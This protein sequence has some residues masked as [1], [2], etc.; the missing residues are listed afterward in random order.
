MNRF[1][2]AIQQSKVDLVPK[3]V[4]GVGTGRVGPRRA[5]GVGRQMRELNRWA[6]VRAVGAVALAFMAA[7][8]RI[9]ESPPGIEHGQASSR[10]ATGHFMAFDSVTSAITSDNAHGHSSTIPIAEGDWV[11]FWGKYTASLDR[12]EPLQRTDTYTQ[13]EDPSLHPGE[14]VCGLAGISP[15]A[16]R[17]DATH[18][19]EIT[20]PMRKG[21]SGVFALGPQDMGQGYYEPLPG[22]GCTSLPG[23]PA[24]TAFRQVATAVDQGGVTHELCQLY[25]V[26]TQE[27]STAGNNLLLESTWNN[28]DIS[29]AFIRINWKD[30][31]VYDATTDSVVFDWTKLDAEFHQASKRGKTIFLALLAGDGIPAWIFDDFTDPINS[32]PVDAKLVVP[33]TLRDTV[34]G[35]AGAGVIRKNASPADAHYI[36]LLKNLVHE[37]VDHLRN[38]ARFFQALGSLKVTGANFTTAEMK[39]QKDCT[40]DGTCLDC[41]CNTQ[42]WQQDPLGDFLDVL[43]VDPMTGAAINNGEATRGGG[44][45]EEKLYDFAN[46]IEN[47]IYAETQGTKSLIFML[48]QAGF[49]RVRVAGD[50]WRESTQSGGPV[51]NDGTYSG[52]IQT[53]RLLQYGRQGLFLTPLRSGG[54]NASVGKLFVPQHAGLQILPQDRGLAGCSQQTTPLLAPN[55]KYQAP[56]PTSDSDSGPGCPN[57]WAVDAGYLG[58]LIGF[59]TNNLSAVNTPDH[60]DSTLWNGTAN[61]R[62]IFWEAYEPVLWKAAV[63]KGT[64]PGALPLSTT[65]HFSS[66]GSGYQKNLSQWDFELHSRRRG[67]SNDPNT[68]N[69]FPLIHSVTFNE[70][71]SPGETKSYY[72]ISPA[73]C[74][75]SGGAQYGTIVVTGN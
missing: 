23:A 26:A 13:I 22:A 28:P 54:G 57:P 16:H 38:D 53:E 47:Q 60:L 69:P 71:L 73:H 11:T 24:G 8:S 35:G 40:D 70:D 36:A 46:E 61:S 3:I 19:S 42:I 14:D 27:V 33:V 25:D 59:Q 68:A 41:W 20:G 52:T 34:S 29:G 32:G 75:A 45:T 74:A 62:M 63:E 4:T 56:M 30:L 55:G 50:Y 39:L 64:G 51:R 2:G 7:C 43:Y 65:N 67:A 5:P 66:M 44:Y 49:P 58:Q 48:I 21:V 17:Y 1:A 9:D 12:F 15:V 10:L 37:V 31:Q 72:F 6:A 18:A